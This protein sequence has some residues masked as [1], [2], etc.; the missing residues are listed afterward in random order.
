MAPECKCPAANCS[1]DVQS[2]L[3]VIVILEGI[4]VAVWGVQKAVRWWSARREEAFIARNVNSSAGPLRRGHG[5][6]KG[7]TARNVNGRRGHGGGH[8]AGDRGRT[9]VQKDMRR[10]PSISKT[11][12]RDLLKKR[13]QTHGHDAD[14]EPAR[15]DFAEHFHTLEWGAQT[16]TDPQLRR[17]DPSAFVL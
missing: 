4:A 16:L 1:P 8:G 14:Q 13:R 9:R 11:F 5:G 3:L 12:T 6:G 2:T 10:R 17:S 15:Q 7:A